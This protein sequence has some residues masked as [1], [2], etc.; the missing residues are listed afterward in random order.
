MDD[1][2]SPPTPLT[3]E[4]DDAI[5]FNGA[6]F[7]TVSLRAPTGADMLKAT[8]TRGASNMQI[9]MQM[10]AA[11]SMEQVPY[12]A[13]QLLPLWLIQQMNEYLDLFGGAPEPSPLAA[14]RKAQTAAIAQSIEAATAS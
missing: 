14:W 1:W 6:T 12:E 9:N 10:I 7:H 3:W 2:A 11:V 8:G 13:V 4:L 5:S